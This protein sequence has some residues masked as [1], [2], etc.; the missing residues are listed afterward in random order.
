MK[1]RTYGSFELMSGQDGGVSG[2]LANFKYNF[3][4]SSPRPRTV[5]CVNLKC[6]NGNEFHTAPYR[7]LITIFD[8]ILTSRQAHLE[9]TVFDGNP[10]S[11]NFIKHCF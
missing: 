11:N 10:M 1:N 6:V 7:G 8:T 4:I 3:L 9:V 2:G 5:N